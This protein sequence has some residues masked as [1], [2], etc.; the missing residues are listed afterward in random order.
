MGNRRQ[1]D[2]ARLN[3]LGQRQLGQRQWTSLGAP[4]IMAQIHSWKV[5]YVDN[6]GEQD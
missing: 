4:V 3:P 2:G 5:I 1:P 6:N